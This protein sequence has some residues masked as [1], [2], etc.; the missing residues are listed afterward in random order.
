MTQTPGGASTATPGGPDRVPHH[1][2]SSVWTR[3]AIPDTKRCSAHA[4]GP[5]FE[6]TSD[7]YRAADQTDFERERDLAL[8]AFYAA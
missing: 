1:F 5:T 2:P 8:V 7:D 4:D 6:A 3:N